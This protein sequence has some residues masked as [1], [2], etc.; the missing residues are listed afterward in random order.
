VREYE[1]REE[2][3]QGISR[4]SCRYRLSS[5]RVGTMP[6]SWNPAQCL[7]YGSCLMYDV[8]SIHLPILSTKFNWYL[9]V[10]DSAL[11]S[12]SFVKMIKSDGTAAFVEL[13]AYQGN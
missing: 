13:T 5:W 7:A 12:Y 4:G 11:D 6:D 2:N 10:P 9:Y 3:L 1:G 8:E